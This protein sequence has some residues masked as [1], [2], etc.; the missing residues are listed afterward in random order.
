MAY[1]KDELIK[2]AL[3]AIDEHKLYFIED[4]TTFVSCSH[5]TFYNYRLHELQDIKDRLAA[6]KISLKRS[7]RKK[8][9]DSKNAILQLAL[10]KLTGTEDEVHRLSGTKT[11]QANTHQFIDSIKVKVIDGTRNRSKSD[12]SKD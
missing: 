9:D 12:I 10:Y 1:K 4:V 7:L 11:E 5:K 3:T 2:Q 8:W 6:N